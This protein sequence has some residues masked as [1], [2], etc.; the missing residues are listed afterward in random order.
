MEKV[1]KAKYVCNK[2]SF[3]FFFFLKRILCHCK[4]NTKKKKKMKQNKTKRF[5][6]FD[7]KFPKQKQNW[8]KYEINHV[9]VKLRELINK[10]FFFKMNS[11]RLELP[12]CVYRLKKTPTCV[13]RLIKNIWF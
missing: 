7:I 13:Y 8:R 10:D 9:Y 5:G 2:G 3:F 6:S 12:T 4:R 1:K 11:K